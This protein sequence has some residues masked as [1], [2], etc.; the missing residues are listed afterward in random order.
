MTLVAEAVGLSAQSQLEED[1]KVSEVIGKP[2]DCGASG[3]ESLCV[4]QA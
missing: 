3:T 4:G 1:G 2:V